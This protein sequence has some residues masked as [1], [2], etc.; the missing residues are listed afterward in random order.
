[1]PS[2]SNLISELYSA[3]A[4]GRLSSPFALLVE[5]QA[6]I[7]PDIARDV[8]VSE[9]IAAAMLEQEELDR[10]APNAFEK[11]LHAI[12]DLS[13]TRAARTA[14]QGIDELLALP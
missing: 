13:E 4:A 5:T 10:L 9:E 14:S 6:A 3:Y 2:K 12:E 11:A 8:A 1:M 7:R